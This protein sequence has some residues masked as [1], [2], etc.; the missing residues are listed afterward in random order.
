MMTKLFKL[1][2]IPIT[3][4]YKSIKKLRMTIYPPDGK[5]SISAPMKTS[6]DYIYD[7]AVSKMGWIEK[8]REQFRRNVRAK[9][10]FQHGEYHYVWGLPYKLEI[11]ER[12]GHPKIALT[13]NKIQLSARPGL[14]QEQKQKLLDT[15]Y[16][17]LLRDAVP[18]V[19]QKWEPRI[20]VTL[21]GVFFRKMK[22]HWGSC[23]YQKQT[24]RLNTELAKKPPECLEYVIV[25]EM[26]HI[27]EPSH[28]RTFYRLMN[29]YL[30]SWKTIRKKMN[31]GEV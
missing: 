9:N 30:P 6:L 24:I 21:K 22:S 7:F 13:E 5:V 12:R 14:S 28:N 17:N 10:H 23:N 20:R 4:E 2:D 16:R 3:V 25:H 1:G 15:W 19:I 8:H 18:M 26:I 27:I 11:I 29:T 31:A